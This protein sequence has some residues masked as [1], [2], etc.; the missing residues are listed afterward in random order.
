MHYGLTDR[1]KILLSALVPEKYTSDRDIGRGK[2]F[3]Y[4]PGNFVTEILDAVFGAG[5]WSFVIRDGSRVESVPTKDFKD[6]S[7]TIEQAPVATVLGRLSYLL[8]P[9]PDTEDE[10]VSK[11]E[12]KEF[13]KEAYGSAIFRGK[14]NEQ[15]SAFKSAGTDALKK[16]ATLIGVG[17]EL[18]SKDDMAK[19][20]DFKDWLLNLTLDEWNDATVSFYSAQINGINQF[21]QILVEKLTE[22]QQQTFRLELCKRM[23][24]PEGTTFYNPLPSTVVRYFETYRKLMDEVSG[25]AN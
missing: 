24:L 20:L 19:Y 25:N 18:Y 4:I 10:D 1:Q 6:P 15:Q 12:P 2:I 5:A 11:Y 23:G 9:Q 8:Y 17:R 7:K 3:K 21:D 22:E 16:C 14:D 13:Y